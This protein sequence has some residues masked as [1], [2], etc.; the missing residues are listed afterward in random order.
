MNKDERISEEQLNAFVDDE[1]E[2]EEKARI[3]SEANHQP[4]L[5]KRLCQQR[6]VKELVKFAY[7]DV[8]KPLRKGTK[9]LGRGGPLGRALAASVLLAF[10]MAVGFIAKSAIDQ[11]TDP[12]FVAATEPSKYLLHVASG[13]PVELAAAL[14]RAEFLLET[15]ADDGVRQVEIVANEQGL[16][17]LRS[18]VTPFAAEISVLQANDVVFYACSKTIQKLENNGVEVRLVPHTIAEYTA[19]DRV[20]TRMQEGWHYEKI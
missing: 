2:P 14:E 20:V 5:D 3:Y 15:A 11:T 6:K 13:D 17:L 9:S 8:P 19:L 1:L 10:G 4:E 16:N 18:D 7:H 12:T